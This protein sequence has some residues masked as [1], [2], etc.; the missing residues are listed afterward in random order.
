M[1]ERKRDGGVSIFAQKQEPSGQRAHSHARK[2]SSEN[3]VASP[4]GH[5]QRTIGNQAVGK[6]LRQIEIESVQTNGVRRNFEIRPPGD[7][8]ESEADRMADAV[9]R[10]GDSSEL[11]K[12]SAG[13]VGGGQQI[14]GGRVLPSNGEPLSD[15]LRAHYES[16]FGHDF[17]GVRVHTGA[18]AAQ[19]ARS[20]GASA[21]AAGRDIVF[22]G[23][24]FAPET[25]EG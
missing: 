10:A 20:L 2:P 16:R 14:S 9:L 15:S 5:L 13:C 17:R 18:Q 4:L 21:Y 11:H 25:A 24:Q 23:K 12:P 8:F 19:S 1:N 6:L 3:V 22:G 7:Y